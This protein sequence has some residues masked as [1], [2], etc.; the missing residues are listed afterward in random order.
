MHFLFRSCAPALVFVLLWPLTAAWAQNLPQQQAPQIRVNVSRV[1][2]GV[3]V[4][5]SHGHFIGGL[6]RRD[7][8]VFDNGVEQPIADFLPIDESAQ[9]VLLMECSPAVLFLGKSHL[10]TADTFLSSLASTDRVAIAC[11]SD[12][13]QL[14]L[15]FTTDKLAARQALHS[16]NF[17]A[18]SSQLNMTASIATV[19]DWLGSFPGKKTIVLLATG[20]D[21]SPDMNSRV[22]QQKFQTSDVRILAISS[23]GDFRKPAKR[24]KQSSLDRFDR[25]WLKQG[26]A[27]AD[28]SL[29]VFSAATGGHVYFPKNATEYDR[30]YQEIAQL[31][32]HE[33]SLAFVPPAPDGRIHSIDVRVKHS[34]Y[35]VNHRQAYLAPS[36]DPR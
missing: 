31:V 35:R 6:Q 26:F 32:R 2:V 17:M 36:P 1:E 15:D 10:R 3:T 27:Q 29:Q 18:G 24:D 33:Y 20:I 7:F 16:I 5:D 11:F 12:V 13:P 34:S 14:F 23:F 21:T 28:Q 30:A 8:H 25:A 9:V 19:L 4:T 22:I